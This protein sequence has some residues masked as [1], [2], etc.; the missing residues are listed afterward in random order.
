MDVKKTN[1]PKWLR[2]LERE[3]WQAELIISGA[4]IFGALQLPGLLEKFQ[5][6]LL[7]NYERGALFLWGFA[8]S[9]W[10]LFVYGL[11]FVFI[12]HF[13][14][15][16]LWIGLVGLNSVY[17]EGIVE[18]KMTSK[19]Y[20]EKVKQEYGDIDGFIDRLDRS[21]SSMF[22]TGFTFAGLFFNLGLIASISILLVNWLQDLGLAPSLAWTIGLLPIISILVVSILSS[23]LSLPALREKEWVKRIHFPLGKFL[24]RLTYPVNTRFTI[25]GLMLISSQGAAEAKSTSS[26]WKGF[27]LTMVICFIAGFTLIRTNAMKPEFV[28]RAYHRLG[29]TPT[30]IDPANFADSDFDGLLFEPQLSAHYP[31]SDGPLWAWVPLPERELATMEAG[32]TLPPIADDLDRTAERKAERKRLVECAQ[33]YMELYLDDVQIPTPLPRREYRTSAGTSQFGVRLE[34]SDRMPEPGSHVIKIVTLYPLEEGETENY[35][36]TYIPFTVVEGG[37]N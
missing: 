30:E 32:C 20:H 4:A 34:L 11:I 10:A 16:A 33:S 26:V 31:A 17:P 36:T 35:R 37:A 8:T 6:Y 5:Y 2:R 27:V 25:T 22:G 18:N 15:R 29:D 7:L 21:A 1:K 14:I 12:F 13:V 24:S 3:S 9:Y 19:D 23:V 28:D